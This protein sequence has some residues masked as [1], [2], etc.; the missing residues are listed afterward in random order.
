MLLHSK[1]VSV[2]IVSFNNIL[3]NFATDMVRQPENAPKK[4]IQM[5]EFKSQNERLKMT[6]EQEK[7]FTYKKNKKFQNHIK[8]IQAYFR[9]ACQ[10]R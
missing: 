3:R 9:I 6:N 5:V 10:S 4:T 7:S 1:K 8:T 2:Y